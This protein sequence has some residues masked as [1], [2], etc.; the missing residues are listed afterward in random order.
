MSVSSPSVAQEVVPADGASD[1]PLP[2]A[3]AVESSM[4]SVSA[5]R[6]LADILA[7]GLYPLVRQ[8][9]SYR[10]AKADTCLWREGES[11]QSLVLILSGK[12]ETLKET[13]FPNHPFVTGIHGVGSIVGEDGFLNDVPCSTTIRALEGCEM[14][15]LTRDKFEELE[16]QHPAVANLILKWMMN[17]ISKRLHNAQERL[18]TIF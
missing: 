4:V 3:S 17:S 16:Q 10:V 2:T 14:L 12:L 5:N 15:V 6:Q 13:E 1:L 8:Y 11:G 7:H 9:L 18:A